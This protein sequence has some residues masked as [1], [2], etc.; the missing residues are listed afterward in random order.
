MTKRVSRSRQFWEEPQSGRYDVMADEKRWKELKQT[1]ALLREA[2]D[3]IKVQEKD[4]PR[5]VARFKKEIEEF[6]KSK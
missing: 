1:E 3:A 6:E 5:V 4:L 2:A